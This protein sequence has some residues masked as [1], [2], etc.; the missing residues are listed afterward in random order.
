MAEQSIWNIHKPTL[1]TCCSCDRI[2]RTALLQILMTWLIS[3]FI[4][5]TPKSRKEGK[6]RPESKRKRTCRT[7]PIVRDSVSS[8]DK[9]FVV[10]KHISDDEDKLYV[11]SFVK[12]LKDIPP[13]RKLQPKWDIISVIS[14]HTSFFFPIT[15]CKSLSSSYYKSIAPYKPRLFTN[16]S[17]TTTTT[18]TNKI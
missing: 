18:T 3:C 1:M 10:H 11:L 2:Y 9:R 8:T 13:D 15:C 5:T 7:W 16:R 12:N 17:T 4:L 14:K 6:E